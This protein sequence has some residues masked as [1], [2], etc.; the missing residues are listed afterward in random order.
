[1]RLI[2]A[3]TRTLDV[4]DDEITRAIADMGRVSEV[5]SG[6]CAGPDR[7]G[8]CWA[9]RYGV[10][11]TRFAPDWQGRGLRAGPERNEA[12]AAYADALL[13]FWDGRSAGTRDMIKRARAHALRVH[14]VQMRGPAE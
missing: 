12:M 6:T 2:I 14:V 1:M 9:A 5:V 8:E 13:A 7:A 4:A 3:G 10:P 11:V